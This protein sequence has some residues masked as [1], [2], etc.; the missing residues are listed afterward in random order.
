MS[1][2]RIIYQ[3]AATFALQE[4]DLLRLLDQARALNGRFGIT[5]ILVYSEGRFMQVLEGLEKAVKAVFH[6]ITTDLRHGK[7]ELLDNGP[8]ATRDFHD[9]HMG[10]TSSVGNYPQLPNFL[11]PLAIPATGALRQLLHEFLAE[12]E[13]PIR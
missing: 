11:P 10:F 1:Y 5:G 12:C 2:Y 13:L 7:L 8:L 9:W 4:C 6:A 3:S